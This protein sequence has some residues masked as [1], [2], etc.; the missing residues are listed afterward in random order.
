M[1]IGTGVESP[2][3]ETLIVL[4]D[5]LLLEEILPAAAPAPMASIIPTIADSMFAWLAVEFSAWRGAS[6]RDIFGEAKEGE[7]KRRTICQRREALIKEDT[8]FMFHKPTKE[9]TEEIVFSTSKK[10]NIDFK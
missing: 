10:R 5:K 4:L 7:E 8:G 9:F 1:T 6:S 2:L 3:S